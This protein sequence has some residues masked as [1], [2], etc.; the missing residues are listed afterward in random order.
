MSSKGDY[1][2][3]IIGAGGS[4]LTAIKACNEAGLMPTCIEASEGLGGL[5]RYTEKV[6]HKAS[7]MQYV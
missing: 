1:R 6:D 3:C 7:V 2:V 5:W 4:G